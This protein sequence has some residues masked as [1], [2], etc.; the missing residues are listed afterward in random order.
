MVDAA[1]SGSL[2]FVFRSVELT[3][4]ELTVL[5]GVD[6]VLGQLPLDLEGFD[7]EEYPGLANEIAMA[8]RAAA[9]AA[10]T[11]GE[12]VDDDDLLASARARAREARRVIYSGE[13][14]VDTN[15]DGVFGDKVAPRLILK[16]TMPAES[17]AVQHVPD[18]NAEGVC[19]VTISRP[20]AMFAASAPGAC[21]EGSLLTGPGT[22]AT[23]SASS[24]WS[25][26]NGIYEPQRALDD[27]TSSMWLSDNTFAAG[28]EDE[29]TFTVDLGRHAAVNWLNV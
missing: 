24:W 29:Q 15:G 27:S 21:T 7:P 13:A 4:E 19:D 6:E 1:S 26:S 5:E 17:V 22:P 16:Y 11:D 12:D 8:N 20:R 14:D 2:T 18:I 9:A 3:D 23:S 10:G 28:I 25:D